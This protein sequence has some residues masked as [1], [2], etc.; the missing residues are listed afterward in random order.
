M[1]ISI[2]ECMREFKCVQCMWQKAVVKYLYSL[3]IIYFI[4]YVH[5]NKINVDYSQVHQTWGNNSNCNI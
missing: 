5:I 1:V 2:G 3:Y 4:Y